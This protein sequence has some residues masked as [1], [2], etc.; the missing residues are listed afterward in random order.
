MT[1]PHTSDVPSDP[2]PSIALTTRLYNRLLAHLDH[3]D[4]LATLTA[5]LLDIEALPH[6]LPQRN[7]LLEAARQAIA[8]HAKLEEY[9]PKERTLRAVFEVAQA[10]TEVKNLDE[11]LLDIVRRSRLL[12]GSDTAWLAGEEDGNLRV[13]AI[14]GAHTVEARKMSVPSNSGIAGYVMRTASV[15]STRDYQ[16]DPE[17]A[18]DSTI[19]VTLAREGIQSALAAPLL[20]D[21]EVIGVLILGDRDKRTHQPWEKSTLATF[22]AQASIAIRNARA[23]EAK[24]AA[25]EQA[26]RANAMLQEKVSQLETSI[27]A[28]DRIARQLAKGGG[29]KDMA[30]VIADLLGGEIVFLD[31][32][33]SEICVATSAGAGALPPRPAGRTDAAVLIA[34]GNSRSEGRSVPL[35]DNDVASRVV[36][37][38]GGGDLLGSLLI[39]TADSLDD[40]EVRIFE[41]GST[42]MAVMALRAEKVHASTQ[43]DASLTVRG[44][45]APGRHRSADLD[46]RAKQHGLDPSRPVIV[47]VVEVDRARVAFVRRRLGEKMRFQAH[48]VTEI[49]ERVVMLLNHQD[50]AS[51]RS[52]LQNA[53]F[54]EPAISGYAAF[55]APVTNPAPLPDVYAGVLRTIGMLQ[56]LGRA[57]RVAY[58]PEL[59]VYAILFREHSATELTRLIDTTLGPLLD[60]DENRG[61]VLADTFLTFLDNAKNARA[62]AQEMGV[63][64]NTV[65]N[66]IDTVERLLG[67]HARE[68]NAL[69]FH[70]AL[71]LRK[72]RE[73]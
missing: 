11:V 53:I 8:I 63:H 6:D 46:G 23:F 38:S 29:L 9:Q 12:L 36:A 31:P 3:G 62:T 65:H 52:E 55:S 24:R 34:S 60:H 54:A 66:R 35:P 16:A 37:V 20:S 48:I 50:P 44:L 47:V 28:H 58:E 26:E 27:D 68:A 15:F 57:E 5:T 70:I 72:L 42:A 10:L 73:I 14:E 69:E 49:D 25:L 41:R 2:T 21:F 4:D 18:H 32:V 45:L 40:H 13:L 39:R 64:V 17:I 19:D 33:G 7:G 1:D 71:R 61:A 56:K 43:H 51:L 67:A 59:S 22:A 30:Q